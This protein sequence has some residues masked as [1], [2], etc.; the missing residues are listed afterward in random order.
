MIGAFLIGETTARAQKKWVDAVETRVSATATV[1]KSA[2]A[3]KMSG[4]VDPT[5]EFLQGL[6]EE[7]L[8]RSKHFRKATTARNAISKI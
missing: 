7:E 4:L 5:I 1:V 2:K 3:V 8:K 6:R